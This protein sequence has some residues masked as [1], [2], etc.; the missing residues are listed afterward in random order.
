MNDN[1]TR[2]IDLTEDDLRHIIADAVREQIG[3]I[4]SQICRYVET[5]MAASDDA[6][7]DIEPLKGIDGMAE[8]LHCSKTK[9]QRMKREGLLEGGYTQIGKTIIVSSPAKLRDAAARNMA[10]RRQ[11]ARPKRV[12]QSIY[13]IITLKK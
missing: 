10:I 13:H 8:A 3:Q 1:G 5:R 4:Y 6:D 9:V 2:L 11:A 7:D 12:N